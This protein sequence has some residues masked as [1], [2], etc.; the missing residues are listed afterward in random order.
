MRTLIVGAE[1]LGRVLAH[2]LLAAGHDVR[3]LGREE[4]QPRSAPSPL[5][6]LTR[7]GSPLD[8]ET[9]AAALAGCD[10]LAAVTSDDAVNAVVALAARRALNVPT[11]VAV[12]ANPARAAALAGLGI[13]V[14][15]PT[16][17]TA[18]DVHAALA[19][20][21]VEQELVLGADAGMY[22]VELPARMG[23]R[24]LDE[25]ERSGELV[26]VALER[27]GRL[28]LSRAGLLIEEGDVLH[29]AAS[30]HDLVSELIHP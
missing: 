17:R 29:A 3:L 1:R 25:L 21:S 2:E 10:A 22:R 6:A 11:V 28:L 7:R 4:D 18:R 19:R 13:H 5:E 24:A 14:H 16:A 9:L 27:G 20:S 30:R 26:P 23:G 12:I 8:R 15:S